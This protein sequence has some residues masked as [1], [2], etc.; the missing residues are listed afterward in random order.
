M[1]KVIGS[2]HMFEGHR[3]RK[4]SKIECQECGA[5]TYERRAGR[6]QKA[7]QKDCKTCKSI[8]VANRE[9]PDTYYYDCGLATLRV[10]QSLNQLHKLTKPDMRWKHGLTYRSE[11][12]TWYN[13]IDRC[14]NPGNRSYHDYGG[15]GI[16]VCD[17]W[18]NDPW[19]FMI[20]MGERPSN[21]HSLDR[22][23]NE[24]IY[25]PEN[26]KW[27]TQAEQNA[28]RR[29]PTYNN[30]PWWRVNFALY[31]NPLVYGPM[32]WKKTSRK[33]RREEAIANGWRPYQT[34][35]INVREIEGPEG[36]TRNARIARKRLYGKQRPEGN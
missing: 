3:W 29:E 6:V 34:E 19:M 32:P 23:D 13:M 28:N 17:E 1:K 15:R 12:K 25:C 22:V 10:L 36:D 16:T 18:L 20:H 8:E 14:Y 4:F 24:Y 26:C 2:H 33:G 27:S 9:P 5:I 21:L 11:Y 31:Q 7:L 30:L 35:L